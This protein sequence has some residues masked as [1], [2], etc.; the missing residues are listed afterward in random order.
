MFGFNSIKVVLQYPC[1][2]ASYSPSQSNANSTIAL[3]V[4]GVANRQRSPVGSPIAIGDRA[5]DRIWWPL[6]VRLPGNWA[7]FMRRTML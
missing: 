4:I 5:G 3:F 2:T 7:D 6:C 1:A